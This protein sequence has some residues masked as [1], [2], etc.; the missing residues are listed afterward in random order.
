MLQA[1]AQLGFWLWPPPPPHVLLQ[2]YFYQLINCGFT[3]A[4]SLYLRGVMDRVKTVTST[5]EKLN[6]SSMVRRP[7]AAA[8]WHTVALAL[9]RTPHGLLGQCSTS[10]YIWSHPV[11]F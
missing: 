11:S 9:P 7:R 3:A 8:L 1:D 6:E 4:Y 5:G 10:L 2:G